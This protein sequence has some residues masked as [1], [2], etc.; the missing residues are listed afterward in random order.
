MA[1]NEKGKI[2][3]RPTTIHILNDRKLSR[4]ISA[5]NGTK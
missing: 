3:K 5:A 2:V 4:R 1:Y